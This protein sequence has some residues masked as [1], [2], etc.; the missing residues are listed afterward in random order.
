MADRYTY[1]PLIGLSISIIWLVCDWI[2][3]K[4]VWKNI[5]IMISAILFLFWGIEAY[6]QSSYWKS[7]QNLFERTLAGQVKT[8]GYIMIWG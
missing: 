5:M 7:T 8:I 1:L 3:N 6:K 4:P 2:E